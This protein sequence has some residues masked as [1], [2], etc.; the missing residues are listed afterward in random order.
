MAFRAHEKGME[1]SGHVGRGVYT[2]LVGDPFRLRQIL[3]NLIG[4][5]IKFTPNGEVALTVEKDQES[6]DPA[7]M[8]FRVRDTGIGIPPD[9]ID[10]IFE[11][12]TQADTS[13]TREYGGTGLGLAIT[14]KLVEL[15][16]RAHLGGKPAGS[17]H[18]VLFHRPV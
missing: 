11:S 7:S 14:R 17:W 5:A 6:D 10:T 8:L 2:S 9:K 12:F 16:G 4:N 18:L 13:T 1:L 15:M 3:I